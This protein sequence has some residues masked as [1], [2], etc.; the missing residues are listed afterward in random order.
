MCHLHHLVF[1]GVERLL[2]LLQ[3]Q[4]ELRAVAA[5]DALSPRRIAL[6]SLGNDAQQLFYIR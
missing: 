4:Y 5:C 2:E 3:P 6:V 1:I